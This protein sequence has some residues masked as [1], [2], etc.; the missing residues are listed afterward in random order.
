LS[1]F[2]GFN[3]LTIQPFN[4][5]E[6][7][8]RAVFFRYSSLLDQCLR[9][10]PH[11]TGALSHLRLC[12][13]HRGSSLPSLC[14]RIAVNFAP[15]HETRAANDYGRGGGVKRS[16]LLDLLSLTTRRWGER[17]SLSVDLAHFS[18]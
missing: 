6:A 18:H 9:L 16:H 2:N 3:A 5:R 1:R 13:F 11:A 4:V 14:W 15:A 12:A 10:V 8:T 7:M 17:I